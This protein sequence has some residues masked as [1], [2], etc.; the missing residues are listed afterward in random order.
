MKMKWGQ[1]LINPEVYFFS[2]SQV[3]LKLDNKG[4][5]L[6]YSELNELAKQQGSWQ[7]RKGPCT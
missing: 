3:N 5:N 6:L 2:S 4:A 1:D 7:E